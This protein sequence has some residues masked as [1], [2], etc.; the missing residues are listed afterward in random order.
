MK[1]K[2]IGESVTGTSHHTGSGTCE[3]SVRFR[4]TKDRD[5]DE[6]LVCVASDGAGSAKYA[7]WAADF[8]TKEGIGILSLISQEPDRVRERDIFGMVEDI[9][10]VLAWEAEQKNVDIHE[11][12]CTLLGCFIAKERS[13][14]FQ[15]GDGAIVRNDGSG[16]Y[17][18]VW[19]PH[20]G[21]YQNTTAFIVDDRNLANLNILVLEEPV[22]EVAVFTDGLQMLALNM[23]ERN[24]HQPFFADLFKYLRMAD[25]QPKLEVL[26]RK[27]TEYLES[28][29]VNNR[30]D[31]DKTLFLGTRL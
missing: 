5:G 31:D 2:A 20:N 23:E 19:W 29:P 9:Y 30:T 21:E 3:D 11:Y 27:L 24:A 13:I 14:F 15:I 10:D 26:S 18:P 17:I 12:S 16:F 8:A 25:D 22:H 6:V 1:W 7:A 28:E 4:V